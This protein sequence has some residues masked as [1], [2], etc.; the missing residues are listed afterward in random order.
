M[1]AMAF[2]ITRALV[3]ATQLLSYCICGEALPSWPIIAH[4]CWGFEK[5]VVFVLYA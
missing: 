4:P 5:I 2:S 1:Q 3:P